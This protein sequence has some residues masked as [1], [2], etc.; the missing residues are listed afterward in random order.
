I[1]FNSTF[2]DG[3]IHIV[4]SS[5]VQIT[6]SY[7]LN[8]T[9]Q[10]ILVQGG[11]GTYISTCFLG[12]RPNI[13]GD[14]NE[15]LFFDTGIKLGSADIIVSNTILFSSDYRIIIRT[16]SNLIICVHT[17]NKMK[18]LGGIR[19]YLKSDA[20]YS[21]IQ[22]C[23]FDFNS[24]GGRGPALHPGHGGFILWGCEFDSQ[25]WSTMKLRV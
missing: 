6:N 22:S 3:E 24:F 21:R 23:Y 20:W 4:D 11:H 25:V 16:Q 7:F 2:T 15:K 9:S 13:G 17:Y 14:K 8:F 10:G 1:F 18:Q 5:R 19:L 12:H